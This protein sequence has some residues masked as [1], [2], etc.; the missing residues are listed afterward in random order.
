MLQGFL[1]FVTL[2]FQD[3]FKYDALE[4]AVRYLPT[5]MLGFGFECQ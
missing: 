2:I 5:G 3:V 1:Y 4:T